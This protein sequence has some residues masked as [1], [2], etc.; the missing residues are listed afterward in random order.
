MR[1][2]NE[3]ATCHRGRERDGDGKEGK[4]KKSKTQDSSSE[5][6]SCLYDTRNPSGFS[7]VF[8]IVHWCCMA[9]R[10]HL[11]VPRSPLPWAP[12]LRKA[13]GSVWFT[14][15]VHLERPRS[16]G[17]EELS[18]SPDLGSKCTP[19]PFFPITSIY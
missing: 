12:A 7:S 19:S 1:K 2:E 6:G 3:E 14:T 9:K 11:D 8:Q 5:T 18:S 4:R 17:E 15:V 10:P 13:A 16:R